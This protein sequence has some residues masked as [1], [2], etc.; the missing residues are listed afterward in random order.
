ML[1]GLSVGAFPVNVTVPL[2]DEL[3]TA[4][5]GQTDTVTSTAASHNLFP[6]PRMP[7]SL[8]DC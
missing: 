6:V 4:T 3:A 8:D 2:M 1:S 7:G 5:L